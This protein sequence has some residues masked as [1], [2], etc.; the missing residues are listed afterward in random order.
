MIIGP[1][2]P[3]AQAAL[4][5]SPGTPVVALDAQGK[6]IAFGYNLSTDAV[7]CAAELNAADTSI[8]GNAERQAKYINLFTSSC[9]SAA[10]LLPAEAAGF[11]IGSTALMFAYNA[12]QVADAADAD[13]FT[14]AA[15]KSFECGIG[16]V[17]IAEQSG[18]FGHSAVLKIGLVLAK[19][20][21]AL[22]A[23]AVHEDAALQ[24][25]LPAGPRASGSGTA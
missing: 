18:L 25:S 12:K 21:S 10:A 3:I 15:V 4:G 23:F 2:H 7:N 5:T 11:G 19:N 20:L 6:P 14:L 22:A 8:F 17:S 1:A 16:A 24:T 13:D 9:D